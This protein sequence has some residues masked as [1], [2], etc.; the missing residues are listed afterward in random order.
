[1]R[2]VC[3]AGGDHGDGEAQDG[4]SR[5]TTAEPMPNVEAGDEDDRA[6]EAERRCSSA[7]LEQGVDGDEGDDAGE[8]GGDAEAFAQGVRSDLPSGQLGS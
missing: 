2:D 7:G 5:R 1:M 4:P 8:D 3:R 6:D